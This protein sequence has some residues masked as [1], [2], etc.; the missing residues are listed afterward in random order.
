M[1]LVAGGL[2]TKARVPTD[3]T[4]NN[5]GWSNGVTN[6]LESRHSHVK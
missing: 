2:N 3:N 5:G 6:G 1:I 4:K